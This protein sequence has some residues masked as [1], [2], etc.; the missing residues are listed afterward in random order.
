MISQTGHEVTI[1][2]E[3]LFYVSDLHTWGR[4]VNR[5]DV[6]DHFL[7][8]FHGG[9]SQTRDSK[10]FGIHPVILRDDSN[11][12]HEFPISLNTLTVS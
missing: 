5:F 7:C 3:N 1:P 8:R 12:L 10:Q 9:R 2:F 4:I 11:R 6:I